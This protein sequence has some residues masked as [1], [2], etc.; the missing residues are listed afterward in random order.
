MMK[1][2][3]PDANV[4]GMDFILVDIDKKNPRG[5]QIFQKWLNDNV[6]AMLSRIAS[7]VDQ[8]L[9]S[10]ISVQVSK[11]SCSVICNC[12][13]DIEVFPEEALVV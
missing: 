1:L 12:Q 9:Y 3:S 8:E 5:C 4:I 13:M 6:D 2:A 10:V 11:H 7:Q